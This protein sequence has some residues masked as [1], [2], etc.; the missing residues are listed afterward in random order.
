K[1]RP[2]GT[3]LG[4]DCR[5]GQSQ[6][7]I[8]CA[9]S[10]ITNHSM[11]RAQPFR[12]PRPHPTIEVGAAD[13]NHHRSVALYVVGNTSFRLAAPRLPEGRD[14]GSKQYEEC[15]NESTMRERPLLC[16]HNRILRPETVFAKR[17]MLTAIQAAPST[18]RWN[19]ST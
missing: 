13:Q 16:T 17:I 3:H 4:G 18:L 14:R 2:I 1:T 9:P 12:L 15:D 7:R 5:L 8:G 19:D 6:F 11:R 10:V